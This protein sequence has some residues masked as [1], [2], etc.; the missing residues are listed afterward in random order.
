MYSARSAELS[1]ALAVVLP[2]EQSLD[3]RVGVER[4]LRHRADD[5]V[6][7]VQHR[8]DGL[9]AP[10]EGGLHLVHGRE[11]AGHAR[12]ARRA[13][14]RWRRWRSRGTAG[15]RPRRRGRRRDQ[16]ADA[17]AGHRVGLRDAVDDDGVV[18]EEG[19]EHGH[20][21][22]VD[23][24]VHQV[25]VDLVGEHPEAVVLDPL[26]DRPDLVRGVDRAGRVGRR[27]EQQHLGAGGAGRLELLDGD[28]VLLGLVG[29]RPGRRRRRRAGSPRGT[30]SSTAPARSP[31]R[32][33]RASSRTPRRWPACRRW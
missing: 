19:A 1:M 7:L 18:G 24:V 17:P 28:L 26:A 12:P 4:A 21:A 11:V 32:P 8:H 27:D 2:A 10:V 3:R 9:P 20:R 30:S 14:R 31:R 13:G 23:V 22:G 6:D 5:A 15:S 29:Q 33:G 25:L 16:P